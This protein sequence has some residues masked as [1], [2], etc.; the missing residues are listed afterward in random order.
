MVVSVVNR[1]FSDDCNSRVIDGNQV[2]LRVVRLDSAYAFHASDDGHVW[3]LIRY[4][5]LG[6]N[7]EAAVGF[8]AQSPTGQSCTATFDEIHYEAR[9]L[10]DIRS[11]E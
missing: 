3:S 4:F 8:S 2:Y 10:A 11:G 7:I 5:S 9:K 1:D 6:D